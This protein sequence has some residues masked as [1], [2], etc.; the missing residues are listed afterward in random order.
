MKT[1][2]DLKKLVSGFS[3]IAVGAPSRPAAP[4]LKRPYYV[5]SAYIDAKGIHLLELEKA[6][7]GHKLRN[8][9]SLMFE[10]IL[11]ADFAGQK[12]Q[13]NPAQPVQGQAQ[14][15][16]ALRSPAVRDAF[17][18]TIKKFK[19]ATS[20]ASFALSES[21]CVYRFF[22]MPRIDEMYRRKAIPIEARKYM[23]YPLQDCLCDWRVRD[24]IVEEKESLGVMF[25]AVHN[26]I[27]T[28]VRDLFEA[29]SLKVLHADVL[30]FAL[31]RTIALLNSVALPQS[32]ISQESVLGVYLDAEQVQ[33]V[34][35]HNAA[36]VLMRSIYLTG[37]GANR[38]N[39]TIERRKLNLKATVD[40]IT[41]Q[42]NIDSLKRVALLGSRDVEEAAL[43]AWGAGLGEELGLKV[44]VIHPMRTL[45][46][47][48]DGA[49]YMVSSWGEIAALG[50]ALRGLDNTLDGVELDLAATFNAEPPKEIALKKIW[51]CVLAT[52][53]VFGLIAGLRMFQVFTAQVRLVAVKARTSGGVKE[54]A[55]VNV[56]GIKSMIELERSSIMTVEV[57][58]DPEKRFY[59]T[60]AMALL[61]EA[62]PREAGIESWSFNEDISVVAAQ[63][64]ARAPPRMQ[65]T[66]AMEVSGGVQGSDALQ[67]F[68]KQFRQDS[69][70]SGRFS[71]AQLS[72]NR[73][74]R[75]VS[76]S[77]QREVL[78]ALT[79]T[80]DF[81][82]GAK[83]QY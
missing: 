50:V 6:A 8:K 25:A 73:M 13:A 38:G 30:A 74:A 27:Y 70:L 63:T 52:A 33:L 7:D 23:P 72:F 68:V 2:V 40:F 35:L 34:L 59:L 28:A 11:G 78:D 9:H 79:F 65:I 37:V 10:G 76:F 31:S 56:A 20:Y 48:G 75:N 39:F 19:P 62:L 61:A 53:C 64:E 47:S 21:F 16:Q 51:K 49:R 18:E 3:G 5:L 77:N 41:R 44:D 43:K 1:A 45:I 17:V 57:L 22:A 46:Q 67:G 4:R 83:S 58:T 14:V 12:A 24:I 15:I 36:P 71:D 82:H 60:P 69:S 80:V 66:G 29:A 32:I 54:L 81:K 55:N 26:D 42:L